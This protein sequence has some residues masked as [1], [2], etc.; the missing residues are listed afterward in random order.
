MMAVVLLELGFTPDEMTGLAVLSTM[1]GVDR[2][3]LGGAAD[4][5]TD[6]RRRPT[7]RSTT[8]TAR[9]ISPR[10]APPTGKEAG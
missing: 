4:R 1:P 5:A 6:P 8:A 9:S 2:P 3:H 10:T 7:S